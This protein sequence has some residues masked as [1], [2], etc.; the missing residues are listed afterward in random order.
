MKDVLLHAPDKAAM[1]AEM[2]A[3]FPQI[4]VNDDAGRFSGF[5]ADMLPLRE[6]GAECMTIVRVS[7]EV[8]AQLALLTSVQVLAEVEAYGDILTELDKDAAKAAI[9]DRVHDQT[10]QTITGI[11]GEPDTIVTPERLIGAFA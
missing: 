11:D 3:V 4:I 9:Y 5:S 8:A 7:P 2:E 1:V 10:P 6:L